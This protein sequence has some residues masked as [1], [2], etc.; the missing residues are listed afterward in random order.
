MLMDSSVD[1]SESIDHRL[2]YCF[3]MNDITESFD[4]MTVEE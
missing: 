4:T 1:F 3:W 2:G